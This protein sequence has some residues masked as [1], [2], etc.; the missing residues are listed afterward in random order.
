MKL[1]FG[2]L[3]LLS[4]G[5]NAQSN[6]ALKK[7]DNTRATT[8]RPLLH[9]SKYKA[10]RYTKILPEDDGDKSKSV[11]DLKNISSLQGIRFEFVPQAADSISV[12]IYRNDK[13]IRT[14]SMPDWFSYTSPEAYVADINGDGLTDIKVLVNNAGNGLAI[15]AYYKI[16]LFNTGTSFDVVY[17]SD[18]HA[19]PERDLDGDGVYEI[20]G[21]DHIFHSD[22]HSY[23]VYNTY[24]YKNGGLVS[25]SSKFGYPLWTKHLN[26][27]NKMIANNI[28]YK[29]RL[30]QLKKLPEGY[31]A[32]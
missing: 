20:L 21:C 19:E 1:L 2:L 17:F 23:W 32:K 11:F 7:A 13:V 28:S 9:F 10:I 24:S 8:Q 25:T 27:S 6:I 3:L 14:V 30:R 4:S 31:F 29:E 22:G 15:E 18:F 5:S 16:F 26:N 12:I